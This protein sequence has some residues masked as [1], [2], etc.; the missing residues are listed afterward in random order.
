[1]VQISLRNAQ[2]TL[3]DMEIRMNQILC[4]NEKLKI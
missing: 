3:K 2:N 4:E 1:M